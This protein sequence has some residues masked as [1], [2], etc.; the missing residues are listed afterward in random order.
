MAARFSPKRLAVTLVPLTSAGKEAADMCCSPH[1]PSM[2][3][4]VIFALLFLVAAGVLVG[5]AGLRPETKSAEAVLLSEIKKLPSSQTDPFD[6]FGFS[7]AVSGDIA[8]VGA[9]W[10]SSGAAYVYERN[11]GGADNWGE[12]KKLTASD[13]GNFFGISVAVSG[14]TI[15]VGAWGYG[16]GGA[17]YIFQRDQGGTDNW[18][19]V[20]KLTA[21]DAEA[22]DR[23]GLSVAL[24]GDTTLVGAHFNGAGGAAYIFQRDQGGT[25]NWG[26]VKKLLA[27]DAQASDNF[28]WSV[29]V[30]GDTAIV[31]A[32]GEGAVGSVT[33]AAYVYKRNEGGVDNWGEVKKLLASDPTHGAKFGYSVALSGDTAVVGAES[34]TP[35]S[36]APNVGAA[37]VYQRDRS[38]ELGRGEEARAL[39][40]FAP[41]PLRC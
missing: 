40:S 31:G 22:G 9:P 28:G 41:G 1:V 3:R 10:E 6:R 27:S 36:S 23:F 25:D 39:E 35:G 32:F 13:G 21:S 7:V 29:A 30:S 26:E 4:G 24:S 16:V 14:D 19:E 17:A 11:A 37:Y 15:L 8:V 20:K 33:G 2:M 38:G 34:Y 18:G 5:P 12:V